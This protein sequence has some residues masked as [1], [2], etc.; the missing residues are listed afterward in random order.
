LFVLAALAFVVRCQARRLER[1]YVRAAAETDKLAR[2]PVI[3]PGNGG[4]LDPCLSAKR[5]YQ[6]ALVVQKRDRLEA[7]YCAWQALAE[8]LSR[9]T[10]AMRAWKG[11]KLPYTLGM[12]DVAGVL[13]LADYLVVG[14][15]VS[16]RHLVH[17]I[18]SLFGN[19]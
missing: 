10:G 9:L 16:G 12:L 15:F 2:T 13:A 6:L 3:Q 5:Q 17:L 8:R 14:D 18:T 7:R 19:G 4:R 11:R 1:K